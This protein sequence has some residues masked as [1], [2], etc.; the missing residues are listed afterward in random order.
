MFYL[1]LYIKDYNN[2]RMSNQYFVVDRYGSTMWMD[3]GSSVVQEHVYE[4]FMD[5]V[6][7]YDIT[8]VHIDDYFYPYPQS[9]VDFPD[10]TTYQN[11]LNNGGMLSRDDWRRDNNNGMVEKLYNGMKAIKPNIQFSISPFGIYRPCHSEGQPCSIIGMDQ[12]TAIYADP[13]LWLTEGWCD[14]MLPQLYWEIEPAAQSYPVLLD[15]WVSSSANPLGINI[16]PG[17]AAYK[18]Q[19]NN[20]LASEIQDQVDITRNSGPIS[21]GNCMF[22]YQ[23]FRDNV[24]GLSDAF[25]KDQYSEPALPPSIT[26]KA[27]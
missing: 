6:S 24:K 25:K 27:Q 12:Y 26:R 11:Y 8:G 21:L 9:G 10:S 1:S 2:F 14:F 19:D 4:I 13:K 17:N 7:R 22:S 20:W 3:P 23:Q 5:V 15:W 16:Y 18:C